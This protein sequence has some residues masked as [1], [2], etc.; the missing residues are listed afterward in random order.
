MTK[1]DTH[2]NSNF[3]KRLFPTNEVV[4]IDFMVDLEKSVKGNIHILTMVDNFSKFVKVYALKDRTAI[5]ASRFVYDYCLVYGIPEK[6][7]SDQ[8]PAF[9]ANLFIQLM[10]QLSIN[11]SRTTSYNPK[12]NGLCEKSNGIVKGFL[13]K[14]VNFFGGEWD[15]WLRELAYVFNSSVHTSTSYT[16]YE[17]FLGRKV[18]IP[19]DILFSAALKNKSETFSISEFKR[20]LSD[21]Y[22]LANEAMNTRQVKALSYHDRKVYVYLP[23]NNREKLS[24]KWA[25]PVRIIKEKHPSYLIEY[26][27]Q[28]QTVTKWKTREKLRRTEQNQNDIWVEQNNT[29]IRDKESSEESD[30]EKITIPR[31]NNRYNLRQDMR[32]PQRYGNMYT[33]LVDIC[34]GQSDPEN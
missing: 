22:E 26:Q 16:P 33:H 24:L 12:A 1:T 23:R 5:T 9:E 11:K 4:S 17:L 14:Y 27:K 21:M 6:I 8:D 28:G 19:T 32:L 34:H 18:R 20:K 29:S 10:K 30:E 31:C 3:G 2:Q 25:G 13:L 15:K 7:Y